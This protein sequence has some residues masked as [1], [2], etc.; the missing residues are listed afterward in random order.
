LEIFDLP[1]P[2]DL[3]N[4]HVQKMIDEFFKAIEPWG[5]AYT[6]ARL[7]FLAVKLDGYLVV[8]A[9]RMHLA[10]SFRA[11]A[12]DWFE[13]GDLVAGH[14]DLVGE[15]LAA[16]Q[17][18]ANG[19][20]TFAQTVEKI[21][22]PDG[23]AM[24]HRGKLV[25]RPE[26]NQSITVGMPDLL[27]AEGL[28]VGDR[29]AVLTMSGLSREMLIPQPQTDWMLKAAEIPFDSVGELCIEYGLGAGYV[30]Q[31]MFEVVAHTGV[32]VWLSSSV[33]D[34]K[35]DLGLWLPPG[36][37]RSQSRLGYRVIDKGAVV[38]RSSV[39]GGKLEWGERSGDIVGHF[40]LDVPRGAVVQ[41]IASYAG[42]AHHVRWFGDPQTF[43]NARAAVLYNVDQTGNLLREYLFPGLPAKGRAADDF[44]SAVAW[45]LWG[46]GFAPVSFGMNAK[47][48]D[49][50]D[51]LAVSPKG[52]F[53]VVECT[54][55]L[56]RAESKL[57]KLSARD[58][59]LRK[60][61]STSGLQHVRVLPVIVTAMTRDEVK[62]DLGA[63]AETGVLV[64]TKEDLEAVLNDGRL[65]F[66]NADQLFEQALEKLAESQHQD[67]LPPSLF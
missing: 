53:L 48:R 10:S 7:T 39:E 27:H 66:A 44:E 19:A 47:T 36:L 3:V 20:S 26:D 52:D 21:A 58:A 49:T 18:V 41:C 8:V 64:L 29:I 24:P 22:S 31:S 57:S 32:Q 38:S 12:K 30:R 35:A 62:A 61:L 42:Q 54:T 2:G 43:Q 56:L 13:A 67:E 45:T 5:S 65:R 55:G 34:G 14:L 4:P 46:L 33:K 28:S 25:L 23:F 59:A 16:G 37:D 1:S 9:A 40:P 63:A 17:T 60:M 50:F 11:P 51:I 6:A 15:N